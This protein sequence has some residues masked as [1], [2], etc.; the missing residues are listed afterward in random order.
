MKI[1]YF[2]STGN[3]LAVARHFSDNPLSIVSLARKECYKIEDDE[4]IGIVVPDHVS[5][6]PRPVISFLEKATLSA[7]YIFGIITYGSYLGTSLL[8][9]SKLCSLDY[10][11]GILMIDNYF[12]LFNQKEQI[13]NAPKKHIEH[14]LQGIAADISVRRRYVHPT[15]R[16]TAFVGLLMRKTFPLLGQNYKRFHVINDECIKCS[17]CAKACP[18]DNII[19]SP[20]PIIGHNCIVC[21]ACRQNCPRNCI[22]FRGEKDTYQFRNSSVTAAD[23]CKANNE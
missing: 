21:G 12:P 22:R 5:A 4:A 3:S 17:T 8:E 13:E 15:G 20:Y 14:Q 1:L 18:M 19:L 2:T 10:G 11:N 16:W 9:L 7:P 6:L 23:I